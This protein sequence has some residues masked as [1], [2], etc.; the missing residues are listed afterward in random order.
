LLAQGAASTRLHADRALEFMQ[1]GHLKGAEG[2]LRK[3]V[4]LSPH[5]SDLVTSHRTHGGHS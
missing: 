5:N 2:E 1:Q 4:E 3:A